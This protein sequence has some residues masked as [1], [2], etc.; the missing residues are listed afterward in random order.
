MTSNR[1]QS[2][3]IEAKLKVR[4]R[5]LQVDPRR[6]T[7][8]L[9]E[10]LDISEGGVFV[11]TPFPSPIGSLLEFS[12]QVP[13]RKGSIDVIGKVIWIRSGNEGG[14]GIE[15]YKIDPEERKELIRRALRGEWAEAED[16]VI[17]RQK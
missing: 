6:G 13:G 9:G 15:F 1:R 7:P 10:T 8:R 16:V 4:F 2:E 14:M 12:I 5:K 3:R 17:R 11:R